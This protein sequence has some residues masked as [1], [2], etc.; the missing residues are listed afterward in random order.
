MFYKQFPSISQ[1]EN[2]LKKYFSEMYSTDAILYCGMQEGI[3][4]LYLHIH[5]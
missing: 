3:Q 4:L 1:H 2:D 5:V